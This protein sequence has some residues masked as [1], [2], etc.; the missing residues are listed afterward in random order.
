MKKIDINLHWN[1]NPINYNHR[2]TYSEIY[3]KYIKN[4]MNLLI[5]IDK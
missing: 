1:I 5:L 2:V 3:Q 4:I